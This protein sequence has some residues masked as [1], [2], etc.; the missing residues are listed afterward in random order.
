MFLKLMKKIVLKAN[1]SQ[2]FIKN[3]AKTCLETMITNM[4]Y[5]ETLISLLQ[6]MGTKKVA[7][8]ELVYVLSLKLIQNLGKK[9]CNDA[10]CKQKLGR[11]Y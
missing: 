11:R 5:N 7:D 6:I 3:E 10:M 9:L 4:K 8:M 1:T 2:S